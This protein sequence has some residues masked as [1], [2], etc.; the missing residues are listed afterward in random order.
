MVLNKFT[1]GYFNRELNFCIE[2]LP[3]NNIK[4]IPYSVL[5]TEKI[6]LRG[7]PTNLSSYLKHKL[8]VHYSSKEM[9]FNTD[10]YLISDKEQTWSEKTIL[11]NKSNND[12]PALTFYQNLSKDL[13]EYSF[14]KHL[15]IPEYEIAEFLPGIIKNE[16]LISRTK[17]DFFSPHGGLVI[18]IDGKQH[19]DFIKADQQRDKALKEYKIET[20]RIKTDSIRKRD[21]E[22]FKKIN[23]I[24]ERLSLSVTVKN[25]K[26]HF[27]NKSYKIENFSFTSIAINRF[28][29]LIMQ[30]VKKG[31]LGLSDKEWKL[32]INS[33][34]IC[35]FNWAEVA[36]KDIFEW[37]LPIST[38]YED[39]VKLPDIK[40]NFEDINKNTSKDYLP[41]DFKL[42]ER[43]D[44]KKS[45]NITVRS[46]Y[47]D[48]IMLDKNTFDYFD[49][50]NQT[51]LE[52][53]NKIIKD[54]SDKKRDALHK[55]L[56]QIYGYTKFKEGQMPI[57]EKIFE[58][59]NTLG[60]LPTGGGKSLCFQLP[61]ILK[62]GFCV[63]VCPIKALMN[64]HVDEMEKYG[65]KNRSVFIN[66]EQSPKEREI[67]YQKIEREEVHFI[68]VSPERFQNAQFRNV[69]K[70]L[71]NKNLI[72][73]LVIDEVHCLSEWGHDFRPSYLALANTVVSILK[74]N[75]PIISLTATASPNVLKNIVIELNI[76][77][78]VY[79]MHLSRPELNYEVQKTENK[80]ENLLKNITEMKKIGYLSKEQAGIVFTMHVNNYMGCVGV[81]ENI[82]KF[83]KDISTGIFSGKAPKKWK[84]YQNEEQFN[85]YKRETQQRF[86]SNKIQLM[87][88]T[89][90]FGMGI[91]KPNIRFSIHYG[92]PA[93]MEALYQETGRTGRDGEKANNIIL[94]TDESK[95]VP[96]SI[97]NVETS[98]NDLKKYVGGKEEF[99][100]RGDLKHQISLITSNKQSVDEELETTLELLKILERKNSNS[101]QLIAKHEVNLYRL[102]QIGIIKDWLVINSF[103]NVYEVNY[104]LITEEEIANNILK[105]IVKYLPSEGENKIHKKQLEKI[106]VS[107]LESKK[108]HLIKYLLQW[109]NDNFLYMRRQSLKTLYDYTKEFE[110]TGA[111][112]FKQKIE[113][114]FKHN[115]QSIM[116]EQYI[117][118]DYE[119]AP[120]YLK[121]IL[122]K[123]NK[124]ISNDQVKELIFILARFLESYQ[125]NPWLNLLSSMCRL[126]TKSFDNPDGKVR[127]YNFITEAKKSSH[128]WSV[129]LENLLDFAKVLD[130]EDKLV[131]SEVLEPHLENDEELIMLHKYLQDDYSAIKY[132]EKFN[133]RLAK[134]Y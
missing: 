28:Q 29:I 37:L 102:L 78:V 23:L 7:M 103:T 66:N 122:T 59:N 128:N 49:F 8:N 127:L 68:F 89:K 50:N 74:L 4:N 119:F 45:S 124:L 56:Y 5:L 86:K 15:I 113:S 35:S 108:E 118:T 95:E 16:E 129:T 1:S 105:Q 99:K 117:E 52:S 111:K 88:A 64:D 11:G 57:I 85:I 26:Q 125:N 48:K 3:K 38:L 30:M 25:Y 6:L 131:L 109:N 82:K 106:L 71:D 41:I 110:I 126:I 92:M 84:S 123:D 22:Y 20:I 101:T 114:Y 93:S 81:E 34:F 112:E 107:D 9:D 32:S 17:V 55:I 24:K 43:I 61:S 53:K 65:F 132:L 27:E 97:H 121:E 91:N 134:V 115:E 69:I 76:K 70:T 73:Y 58:Q 79:R 39:K 60:L 80:N 94:F 75:V 13:G 2:N 18:E 116:I 77:E 33:D 133:K 87:C 51:A 120:P 47:I 12:V 63:V 100:N 90:S 104:K 62:M 44:E 19:D 54:I 14:I 46:Y 67:I 21:E 36:I 98:L 31:I 10:P 72:S 96:P 130:D 83:N 42:F 40:I